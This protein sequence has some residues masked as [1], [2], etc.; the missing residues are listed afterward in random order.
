MNR[1]VLSLAITS[2]LIV[3]GCGDSGDDIPPTTKTYQVTVIDGYL[4]NALVWL[5]LNNDGACDATE[6][7]TRSGAGGVAELD[8]TNI[9][10][11]PSD[12]LLRVQ[13]IAGE[14]ID[15]D[16]P[17]SPIS[18]GFYLAAPPGVDVV[19]PLTTLVAA[20]MDVSPELSLEQAT[21]QVAADLGLAESEP[22]ALLSN[23]IAQEQGQLMAVAVN[24]TTIMTDDETGAPEDMLSDAGEIAQVVNDAYQSLSESFG[25]EFKPADLIVDIGSDGTVG[26]T[27]GVQSSETGLAWGFGNW[28]QA[29]WN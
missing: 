25:D 13:A 11:L 17:D 9:D 26:V 20:R 2:A 14:T 23:Y 29:N 15:E 27:Y 4:N 1:L 22:G 3:S 28:D 21:A 6:P 5:D 19:T 16:H 10:G 24:L 7:Q 18:T 12:Y 8:V